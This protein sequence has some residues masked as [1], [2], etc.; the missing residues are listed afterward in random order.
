M[1][2]VAKLVDAAVSCRRI[3]YSA[4]APALQV[5]ILPSAPLP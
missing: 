4:L 5:R 1:A 2:D 3:G